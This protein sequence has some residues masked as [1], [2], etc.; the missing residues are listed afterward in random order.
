MLNEK[1]IKL[2]KMRKVTY[3]KKSVYRSSVYVTARRQKLAS[4]ILLVASQKYN[5]IDREKIM[6]PLV[7]LPRAYAHIS[8][9]ACTL[10]GRTKGVI[11]FFRLSRFKVKQLAEL[12]FLPGVGRLAW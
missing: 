4:F 5:C 3:S 1:K 7:A 2:I 10:T 9:T 6:Q 8:P 12:G 11:S